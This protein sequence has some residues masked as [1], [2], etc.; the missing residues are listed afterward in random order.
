M[1]TQQSKPK[2]W[3][4]GPLWRSAITYPVETGAGVVMT[5]L[6]AIISFSSGWERI[7]GAILI[8]LGGVVAS[9]GITRAYAE[10]TAD[11]DF[12]SKM[13]EMASRLGNASGEIHIALRARDHARCADESTCPSM[14]A[15]ST[16]N[17]VSIVADLNAIAGREYDTSRLLSTA[18]ALFTVAENLD[19]L[20]ANQMT[21]EQRIGKLTD[22]KSEV[23]AI[24]ADLSAPTTN[25]VVDCPY[26]KKSTVVTVGVAADS[27]VQPVCPDCGNRFRA[28]RRSSGSVISRKMVDARSICCPNCGDTIT[29]RFPL[30]A[31][32]AERWCLKCGHRLSIDLVKDV[33][34][35][36]PDE[37]LVGSLKGIDP[38]SGHSL[39]EC[40]LC[41]GVSVSFAARDGHVF[42]ACSKDRRLIKVQDS[43]RAECG[44]NAALKNA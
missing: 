25:E 27:E 33:V 39:I 40:P 14:I 43:A 29:A 20:M 3:T 6:G 19:D 36:S 22:I 24:A 9:S 31:L 16:R 35:A 5:V 23:A 32:E 21:D 7:P 30:D 34:S 10:H 26:C 8:G 17:L 37:P 4:E 44:Q 13:G 1:S 41:Q 12:R 11:T 15:Q 28:E 38:K 42:A 2:K 18:G